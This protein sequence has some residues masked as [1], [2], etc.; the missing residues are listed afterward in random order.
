MT[1]NSPAAL[2]AASERPSEYPN[3]LVDNVCP[4]VQAAVLNRLEITKLLLDKGHYIE[5]PHPKNCK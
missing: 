3:I 4:I 5:K 1:H 2:R